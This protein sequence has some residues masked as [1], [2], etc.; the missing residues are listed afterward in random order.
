MALV[1]GGYNLNMPEII[2]AI[3]SKSVEDLRDKLVQIPEGLLVHYDVL[4]TDIW[5]PI[6]REFE[7]HLMVS[8]PGAIYERW[9]ERGAKRILVHDPGF[10]KRGEVELGLA[11][12]MHVSLEDIF[13]MFNN[14]DFIQLMSI[15]EIG[16]QGH[17]FDERVFDRIKKV[18]EHFPEKVLAIDGGVN[19][20]T[21]EKLMEL[22]VGRLVVGSG[23]KEIWETLQ[24]KK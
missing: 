20:H 8:D 9:V 16:E 19:V 17:P 15:A 11:I 21:Y 2:P 4:E 14:F 5:E 3:L 13:P 1:S 22:G 12:E 24:T 18:K 10:E 7:A 23:F 6:N